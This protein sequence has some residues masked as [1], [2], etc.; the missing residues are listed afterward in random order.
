[1]PVEKTYTLTQ[2]QFDMVAACIA[3]ATIEGAFKDCVVPD[4]GEK[5][6]AM[7]EKVRNT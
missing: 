3:R 5:V 2:R 7:L 1:M 4:I 6:G